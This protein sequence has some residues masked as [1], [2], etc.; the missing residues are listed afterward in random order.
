M[1]LSL[2]QQKISSFSN[3]ETF[4]IDGFP[5]NEENLRGWDE[6]MGNVDILQVLHFTCSDQEMRRRIGQRS[7]TSGRSDDNSAVID[8]RLSIFSKETIPV[9]NILK[10]RGLVE[11]ISTESSK[12]DVYDSTRKIVLS[13]VIQKR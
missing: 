3:G 13:K 4:L 9:L 2:L 6:S 12:Q 5:R 10:K 1:S 8:K 7:L 11:S